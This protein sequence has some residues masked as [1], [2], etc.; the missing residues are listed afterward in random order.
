MFRHSNELKYFLKEIDRIMES[1]RKMELLRLAEIVHELPTSSP[2][3]RI[4]MIEEARKIIRL[5]K[6]Y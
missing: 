4:N 3:E 5:I 6:G 2:L 1:K